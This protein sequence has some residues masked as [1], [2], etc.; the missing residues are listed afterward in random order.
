MN[1]PRCNKE[2]EPLEEENTYRPCTCTRERECEKCGSDEKVRYYSC[3]HSKDEVFDIHGVCEECV[4]KF[5][6][7]LVNN[8]NDKFNQE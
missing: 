6:E 1:C 5:V 8:D 3:Y 7:E 4:R 2:L